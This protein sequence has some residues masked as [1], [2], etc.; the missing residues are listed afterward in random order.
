MQKTNSGPSVRTSARTGQG[1]DRLMQVVIETL[2]P[3]LQEQPKCFLEGV[4]ISTEDVDVVRELH[5]QIEHY[6]RDL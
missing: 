4:P 6:S 2:V 1:I 3:E 5:Q